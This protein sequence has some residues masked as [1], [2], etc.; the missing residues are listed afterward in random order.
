ML[1]LCHQGTLYL[2]GI[3]ISE[4]SNQWLVNWSYHLN[5]LTTLQYQRQLC[6][7]NLQNSR[8]LSPERIYQLT[9]V[10]LLNLQRLQNGVIWTRYLK[11]FVSNENI[12]VNLLIGTKCLQA[13]ES[14][15]LNWNENN[16]PHVFVGWYAVGPTKAS[17]ND[18]MSCKKIASWYRKPSRT[19]FC[20]LK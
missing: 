1:D 7:T 13:L 2:V 9:H 10:R 5:Y 6:T 19:L 18:R 11:K 4:R 15:E 17:H 20:N 12:A 8:W 14:V 16:R 3:L